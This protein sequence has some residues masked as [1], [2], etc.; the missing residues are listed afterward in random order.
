MRPFRLLL[1]TIFLILQLGT[2][3]HALAEDQGNKE[4]NMEEWEMKQDIVHRHDSIKIH[5]QYYY[6][7]LVEKH[8]PELKEEWIEINREKEAILK[9]MRE[10]KKEGKTFDFT[11]IDG[12]WKVKHE[13]IHEEFMEVVKSRD[14]EK[15]KNILPEIINLSKEWNE[16]YRELL[17]NMNM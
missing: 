15:I 7:L 10:M 3:I 13:R 9:K 12:E 5:L 16:V 1:V 17:I 14:N 6:E 2:P 8:R 4:S 11:Q